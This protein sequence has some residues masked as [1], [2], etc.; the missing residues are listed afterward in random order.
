VAAIIM[1]GAI[2]AFLVYMNATWVPAWVESKESSH[3]ADVG[4]AMATWAIDAEDHAA[5][6]Q[7]GSRWSVTAPL[8]VSGLPMLGTGA[9]S[10]EISLATTPTLNVS[11]RSLPVLLAGGGVSLTTHTLRYP[12][13]TITYALG[14]LQVDQSDGSWV[15]LRSLV[16]ASRAASGTISLAIQAANVTGGPQQAGGNGNALVA[17]TLTG[18]TNQTHA[19]GNVTIQAQGVDAGAWRAALNRTLVASGL[20][21]EGAFRADCQGF[22]SAKDFCYTAGN[23]TA[24]QVEVVLYNV[25]SGWTTQ[26][27]AFATEVR[28]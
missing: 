24:S 17:G 4:D 13:Q 25:G 15:D 26:V 9:S 2:V 6:D 12:N 28:S 16:S 5:R 19:A 3:A 14:A 22:V 8:G 1:L 21:G 11:Q 23:N 27:A 10:G 7:V 20:R 18:V